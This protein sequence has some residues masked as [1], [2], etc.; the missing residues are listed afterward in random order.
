MDQRAVARLLAAGRIAVGVGLLAAPATVARSWGGP[1]ASDPGAKLFLR[2]LGGRFLDMRDLA[3]KHGIPA[4][5]HATPPKKLK[6]Q[7]YADNFR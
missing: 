6:L 1:V 3:E 4:R 7:A 2:A 5:V